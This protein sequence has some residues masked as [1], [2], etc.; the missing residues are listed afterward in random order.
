MEKGGL[1]ARS[2]VCELTSPK[3]QVVFQSQVET[4]LVLL[5]F[6]KYK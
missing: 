3:P 5:K 2:T 6:Y 4:P 1:D